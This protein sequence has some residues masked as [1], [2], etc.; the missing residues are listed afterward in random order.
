MKRVAIVLFAV[1][2]WQLIYG[3]QTEHSTS[4]SRQFVIYGAD[5]KVR[6]AISGLAEQTL[7]ETVPRVRARGVV[8]TRW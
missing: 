8:S 2:N 7:P 6:G 3:A 1:A 4:P 5:A